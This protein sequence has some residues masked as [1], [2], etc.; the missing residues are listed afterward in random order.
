MSLP[1]DLPTNFKETVRCAA[2]ILMTHQRVCDRRVLQSEAEQLVLAAYRKEM[3]VKLS[4][5]DLCFREAEAVPPSVVQQAFNWAI[6]RA[7][8]GVLQYLIGYQ[9]FV[10]H[11]YQVDATV[12]VPRPETECL[13]AEVI[14]RLGAS[15]GC[16]GVGIEVGL[17]SGAISIELL[18]HWPQLTVLASEF[19]GPAISVAI[20]NSKNIL[21]LVGARR[22]TIL[23][24]QEKN[25]VLEPFFGMEK[26]ADFLVTNPP[27][28]V[29]DVSEVEDD[30]LTCEP[31]DALF[32]PP[33][34][35][36]MFYRKIA[37]Q[38]RGYIKPEGWVFAEVPHERAQSIAQL[39]KENHWRTEVLLDL[40]QRE[41]VLVAQLISEGDYGSN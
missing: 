16:P 29:E 22:L 17:G 36:L 3:G 18:S 8:G 4:R 40:T 23:Q 26:P 33:G 12:L 5:L 39:F 19:S 38:G 14:R 20:K 25:Q 32:A 30:V 15:G 28:L 10:N 24:V 27:Y 21:G 7:N 34:D 2:Q 35:P 37:E 1:Q 41:R 31:H 11:E 9:E 6:A 13:V